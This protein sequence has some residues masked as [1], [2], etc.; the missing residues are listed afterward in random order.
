MSKNPALVDAEIVRALFWLLLEV[1]NIG[2]LA[3]A[4]MKQLSWKTA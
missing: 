3:E 4:G 1:G 2:T